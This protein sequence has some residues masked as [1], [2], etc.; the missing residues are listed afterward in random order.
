MES[1][2]YHRISQLSD[3]VILNL[4]WFFCSLPIVTLF[5]ATCGLYYAMKNHLDGKENNVYLDF[6]KGFKMVGWKAFFSQIL[7]TLAVAILVI[8]YYFFTEIMPV[9][10]VVLYAI[11]IF[12]GFFLVAFLI[13]LFPTLVHYPAGSLWKTYKKTTNLIL[14][15]PIGLVISLII[16]GLILV[17]LNWLPI[18]TML[19]GVYTMIYL[20]VWTYK[21]KVI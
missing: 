10:T 18:L 6:F 20:L 8:D 16:I 19:G 15:K 12:F 4:L 14:A 5:P 9:P 17:I 1:E 13:L 7:A 3:I 21:E 2:T 11:T